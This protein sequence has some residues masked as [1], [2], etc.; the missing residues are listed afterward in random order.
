MMMMML[1]LLLLLL[2]LLYWRNSN[3]SRN[4]T[5]DITADVLGTDLK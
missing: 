4:A 5:G 3:Y 1:L 2:L